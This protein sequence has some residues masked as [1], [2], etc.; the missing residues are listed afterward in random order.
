MP[1]ATIPVS[2]QSSFKK[3]KKKRKERKKEIKRGQSCPQKM[4]KVAHQK[5]P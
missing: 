2:F 1:L 4:P 5:R 3:K